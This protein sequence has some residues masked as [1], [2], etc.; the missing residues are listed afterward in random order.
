MSMREST[1][2]AVSTTPTN[3]SPDIAPGTRYLRFHMVPQVLSRLE[4]QQRDVSAIAHGFNPYKHD[5]LGAIP[6]KLEEFAEWWASR[7]HSWWNR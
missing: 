6:H 2:Q 3:N 4:L 5:R 1:P 7:P